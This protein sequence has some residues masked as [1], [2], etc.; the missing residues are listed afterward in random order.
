MAKATAA[1]GKAP[2]SSSGGPK[3]KPLFKE[4]EIVFAMDGGD[5]YEAR[6]RQSQLLLHFPDNLKKPADL[7]YSKTGN[8]SSQKGLS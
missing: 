5:L 8:R 7:E 6:V 3:A 4:G 2:A 1:K